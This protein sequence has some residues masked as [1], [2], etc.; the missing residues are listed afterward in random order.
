MIKL[1]LGEVAAVEDLSGI[2]ID[3]IADTGTP[4]GRALAAL[5]MVIKNR[6]NPEFTFND[7]LNMDMGEAAA[8]VNF[9]DETDEVKN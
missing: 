5:V 6:T 3:A 2:S 9:D 8:L 7:A 1:T 4:K